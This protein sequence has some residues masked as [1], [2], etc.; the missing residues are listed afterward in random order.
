MAA[1]EAAMFPPTC[2]QPATCAL[3]VVLLDNMD[4]A[5]QTL[6][7][8]LT[9]ITLTSTLLN[10]IDTIRMQTNRKPFVVATCTDMTIVPESLF[11]LA[12]FGEPLKISYPSVES[13]TTVASQALATLSAPVFHQLMT[14]VEVSSLNTSNANSNTSATASTSASNVSRSEGVRKSLSSQLCSILSIEI[15]RRTQV[16]KF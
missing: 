16:S 14:L 9:A 15:A 6:T 5:F 7:D 12:R 8:S 3:H 10:A 4:V 13:R 1:I 11:R 2:T